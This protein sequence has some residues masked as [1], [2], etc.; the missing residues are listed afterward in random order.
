MN[1]PAHEMDGTEFSREG[2]RYFVY[3]FLSPADPDFGSYYVEIKTI[4]DE[5]GQLCLLAPE[6]ENDAVRASIEEYESCYNSTEE[7]EYEEGA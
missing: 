5:N 4:E 6:L 7:F 1:N 2:K 3:G